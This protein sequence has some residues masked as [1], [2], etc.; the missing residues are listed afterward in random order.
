[1]KRIKLINWKL[2]AYWFIV[3]SIM[4]V[5]IIPKF[6]NHNPITTKRII[7]GIAVSVLF[8]FILGLLSIPKNDKTKEE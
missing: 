2:V 3:M 8:S 7:I 1:M 4:N 5:Y 6:I